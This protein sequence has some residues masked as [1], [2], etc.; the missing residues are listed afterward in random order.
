MGNIVSKGHCN[1][2]VMGK[3]KH[4][5]RY[6]KINEGWWTLEEVRSHVLEEHLQ[7]Q[8]HNN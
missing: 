8:G 4:F 3:C 5:P 7:E 6:P 1:N 2:Q